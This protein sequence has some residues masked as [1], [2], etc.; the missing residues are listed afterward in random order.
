[1]NIQEFFERIE[2]L[3]QEFVERIA[4][5]GERITLGDEE[6]EQTAASLAEEWYDL[7]PGIS[8]SWEWQEEGEDEA[9][10]KLTVLKAIEILMD[11]LR[12]DIAEGT[13][14]WDS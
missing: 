2:A 13:G 14:L 9:K 5:A 6:L 12:K 1:M 10:A 7:I 4:V 11:R 3:R 8:E